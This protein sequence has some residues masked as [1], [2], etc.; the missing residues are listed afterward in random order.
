MSDDTRGLI[1]YELIVNELIV[2]FL[3]EGRRD[4]KVFVVRVARSDPSV[5][6]FQSPK[7]DVAYRV[8]GNVHVGKPSKMHKR[9][10]AQ[11]LCEQADL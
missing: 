11:C 6:T 4:E 5:P 10:D 8:R 3:A 1:V 7:H 9:N 2:T